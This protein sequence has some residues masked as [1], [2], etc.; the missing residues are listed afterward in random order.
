MLSDR[1]ACRING[2]FAI[3]VF[4]AAEAVVFSRGARLCAPGIVADSAANSACSRRVSASSV[5]CSLLQPGAAAPQQASARAR[6][7][8]ERL[9]ANVHAAR[10]CRLELGDALGGR[11]PRRLGRLPAR[12]GQGATAARLVLHRPLGSL[13]RATL[14]RRGSALT[15]QSARSRVRGRASCGQRF[16]AQTASVHQRRAS[17]ARVRERGQA[18]V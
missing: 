14:C 17:R 3:S 11:G 18:P 15:E 10:L 12:D 7:G 8:P 1:S 2:N 16:R 13:A 9:L 4:S 5:C 6:S